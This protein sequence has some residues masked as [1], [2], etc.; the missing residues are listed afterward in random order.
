MTAD[1][2]STE[3]VMDRGRSGGRRA[4]GWHEKGVKNDVPPV[5][6]V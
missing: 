1:K 4:D 5:K 6:N 2:A 3:R